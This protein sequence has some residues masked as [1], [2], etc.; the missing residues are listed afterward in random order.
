MFR[1]KEPSSGQLRNHVWGTSS[2]SAHL[3]IPNVN[4][5]LIRPIIEPCFRYIKWKCTF[6]DPKCALSLNQ[7]NY[8]TIFEVHQVKVHIWGS[9][10]CT[11]TWSGQLLIQVWGTSSESAQLGSQ[12]RTFTWWGQLLNHVWGPSSESVHLWS[13]KCASSLDVT[14][15]WFNNWPD[16]DSLSR[17]MSPL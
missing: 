11:F 5:H 16:D 13:Q 3:G 10:M 2:E 14:Q 4:F 9:Q 1:V 12:M 8:W 7:A 17:N 15:T 6:G